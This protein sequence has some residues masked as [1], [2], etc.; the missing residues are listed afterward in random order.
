MSFEIC[1]GTLVKYKEEDNITDITI[2]DGVTFIG[3][4]AFESCHSLIIINIPDIVTH[5]GDVL[6]WSARALKV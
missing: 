6:L 3:S 2:L 1:C 4:G 5:I